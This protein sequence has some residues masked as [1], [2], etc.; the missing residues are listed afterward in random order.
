MPGQLLSAGQS[1]VA[2]APSGSTVRVVWLSVV[3]PIEL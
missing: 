1:V 3:V 2:P